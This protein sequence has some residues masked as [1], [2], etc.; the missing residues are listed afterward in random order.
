MKFISKD[1]LD[2]DDFLNLNGINK[3][4][5]SYKHLK[6]VY[7][8]KDIL[9]S[10]YIN[11][12]FFAKKYRVVDIPRN[13]IVKKIGKHSFVE[14]YNNPKGFSSF[15]D[16]FRGDNRSGFCYMCGALSA[17]TLDHL[18]PKDEYPEFSFFSKNLIPSCDCNQKKKEN[19]SS[20][21]NPHFYEE[22]DE[23]LYYLDIS[24][25]GVINNQI[26]YDFEIKVKKDFN[27]NFYGLI[28]YHL[29]NHIL[30]FSD[31]DNYMR[32]RCASML[33]NPIDALSIRKKIS[34]NQLR[35]KIEDFYCAAKHEA[36]SSNRWDVIFYKSL[37][38]RSVFLF[39]FGEIQ[40]KYP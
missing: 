32:N 15:I 30:K 13:S 20:G 29:N 11:Y 2:V 36:K 31:I 9:K 4:P 7:D 19:I 14:H 6:V 18:L 25:N 26:S 27:S 35:E 17:G 24:L 23:E 16:K 33:N 40:K 37:L 5:D 1:I 34:K 12:I 22:C 28:E 3:P 8:N 38:K 21:L 10:S 39:I